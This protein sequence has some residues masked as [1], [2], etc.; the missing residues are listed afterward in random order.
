[1]AKFILESPFTQDFSKIH[2]GDT[3]YISGY[4]YTS[5]D[6]AHK[7]LYELILNGKPL[8]VD[9]KNQCIYY[10]GPCPKK[11]ES[12][13]GPCGPTTSGRMDKY[14]PSLLDL[15]LKVMIGKGYRSDDVIKS[16]IKNKCLYLSATG[17]AGA[18]ISKCVKKAD[19]IAFPELGAEAIYRLYVERFPTVVSIDSYGKNLYVEG[20]KKYRELYY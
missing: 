8:P 15:G 9:F 3:V 12:I 10:T 18:L 17:G 2:I 6:A 13:I 19:V 7:R 14:T 16:I 4:I 1:M 11:P 20:V 5:R